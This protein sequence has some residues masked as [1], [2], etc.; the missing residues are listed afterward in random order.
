MERVFRVYAPLVF[1]VL[2]RGTRTKDG[3]HT[4]PGIDDEMAREDLLHD[5][6]MEAF[7]P[8][9]RARYDGLRSFAPFVLQIAR[10][11]LID[12]A[13]KTGRTRARLDDDVAL[14]ALVD[15]D[16]ALAPDAAAISSEER[17]LARAFKDSLDDE[18][19]AFVATRFEEGA[20]QEESAR[21]LGRS[22][23]QI[24]TLEQ[25]IRERFRAF[26]G[27][28]AGGPTKG[29]AADEGEGQDPSP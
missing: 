2:A 18:E 8:D 28:F 3:A 4:A 9:V 7:K 17:A 1:V 6:F 14:D 22:R 19:R 27:S 5:V 24:R 15:D 26:V 25:K 23:Q 20:S 11:R 12:H 13:R 16:G 21:A 29:R 10:H